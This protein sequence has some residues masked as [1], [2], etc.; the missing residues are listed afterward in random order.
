MLRSQAV[1]ESSAAQSAQKAFTV[2]PPDY[3]A[4]EVGSGKVKAVVN[5]AHGDTVH[6]PL[7][8]IID[9]PRDLDGGVNPIKLIG[10][11][12]DLMG[13]WTNA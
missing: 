6:V 8:W 3:L 12:V 2:P 13:H 5:P 7:Q 4:V 9:P 11:K 1:P 10:G